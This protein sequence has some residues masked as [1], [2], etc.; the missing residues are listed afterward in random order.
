[1]NGR[2]ERGGRR[3]SDTKEV[4]TVVKAAAIL[5]VEINTSDIFGQFLR[6]W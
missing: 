4:T 2:R 3:I 5:K 1:M 6:S